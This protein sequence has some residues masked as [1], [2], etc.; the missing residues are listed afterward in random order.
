MRFRAIV[1]VALAASAAVLALGAAPAHALTTY[2][3]DPALGVLAAAGAAPTPA[4]Q[5]NATL[6][7]ADVEAA[8][9]A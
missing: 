8:L 1:R 2:V 6:V 3:A 5:I 7:E 4:A 9:A